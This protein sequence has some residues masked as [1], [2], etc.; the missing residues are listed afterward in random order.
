METN[1]LQKQR[2]KEDIDLRKT[3]SMIFSHW[4]LFILGLIIAGGS[5][6]MFN[7]YT[8]PVYQLKSSLLVK[9]TNES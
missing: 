7:R 8:I 9:E 1:E 3:L 2:R 5:A 6:W 4:F